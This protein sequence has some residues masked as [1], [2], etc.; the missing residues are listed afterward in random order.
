MIKFF[1]LLIVLFCF[2]ISFS[3]GIDKELEGSWQLFEI[4]DN[5][6]G[7]AMKPSHKSAD[8]YL[9]YVKFNAGSFSYNLEVNKCTNEYIAKK[10]R[11]IEFKYFSACTEICC[12]EEF[13]KLLTYDEVNKYYIKEG[14][15][16]ILVSEN[17]IFYLSKMELE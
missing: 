1:S 12:D 6:T 13:S 11:T 2:N 5:M 7:E 4:I 10:D 15:T 3:Q 9:Y 16:L 8:N 17:R 14:K